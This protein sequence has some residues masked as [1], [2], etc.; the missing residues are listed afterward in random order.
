MQ[1]S[2]QSKNGVGWELLHH[3]EILSWGFKPQKI[4]TRICG[5]L[6]QEKETRQA[7]WGFKNHQYE[8]HQD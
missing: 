7:F 2:K 8:P 6:N 3:Q 5:F 1:I 4:T